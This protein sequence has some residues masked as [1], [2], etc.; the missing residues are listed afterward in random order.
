[1]PQSK[2]ALILWSILGPDFLTTFQHSLLN[3]TYSPATWEMK[4]RGR[5]EGW[6]IVGSSEMQNETKRW[7]KQPVYLWT[8]EKRKIKNTGSQ[9]Q[10]CL[11]S[12]AH[13]FAWIYTAVS[14]YVQHA[15][16]NVLHMAV[17]AWFVA[18]CECA[19]VCMWAIHPINLTG[20]KQKGRYNPMD[21]PVNRIDKYIDQLEGVITLVLIRWREERRRERK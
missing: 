13:S 2:I 19:C 3:S 5:H 14:L 17:G 21:A 8:T 20:C 12:D 18:V 6:P 16:V 10:E 4:Q 9:V 15:C 11:A 1:M 7:H